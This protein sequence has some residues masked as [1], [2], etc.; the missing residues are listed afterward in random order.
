M[1]LVCLQPFALLPPE[2]HSSS[3]SRDKTRKA[4]APR[5]LSE[6]RKQVG[7][8]R[9]SAVDGPRCPLSRCCGLCVACA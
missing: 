7:R 2:H 9:G 6:A 5:P 3:A 4:H 8:S 1:L